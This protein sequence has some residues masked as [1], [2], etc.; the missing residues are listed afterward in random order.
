MEIWSVFFFFR[1]SY[2][3]EMIEIKGKGEIKLYNDLS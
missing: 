3:L 1:D 2:L